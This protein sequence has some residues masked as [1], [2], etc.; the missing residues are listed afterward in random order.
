MY[1]QGTSRDSIAELDC[2]EAWSQGVPNRPG[3]PRV[4]RN[5]LLNKHHTPPH[6]TCS[7]PST[8]YILDTT[9]AIRRCCYRTLIAAAVAKTTRRR[10]ACHCAISVFGSNTTRASGA[11]LAVAS[12]ADPRPIS[13]SRSSGHL[14]T[15]SSTAE[16]HSSRGPLRHTAG[17]TQLCAPVSIE[18]APPGPRPAGLEGCSGT[19]YRFRR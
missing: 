11:L 2:W 12:L 5:A 6:G 10:C 1:R 19:V 15:K 14:Y 7:L 3:V 9:K 8:T 17:V 18:A 16:S 13:E 4:R